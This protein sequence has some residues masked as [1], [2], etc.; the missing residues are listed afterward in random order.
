MH[1]PSQDRVSF[2]DESADVLAALAD[3]L[4]PPGAGFPAP[5]AVR[6]VEDF[7]TRY[8]AADDAAIIYLPAVT[9]SDVKALV[10]RVGAAFAGQSG[11]E[12][13]TAV[14]ALENDDAELFAKLRG[15]VYAGYY[16]RPEVR[17]AIATSL[18]AGRDF[19]GAPQ[20]YGYVDV[21]EEWD[22]SLLNRNG[23][24]LK[25]DEVEPVDPEKLEAL[26]ASLQPSSGQN[27]GGA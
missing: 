12:R 26:V 20:P 18:E 19:R 16:S 5:S 3:T 15:L 17:S 6:I 1:G 24:Y 25:T 10:Q 22:V 27:G 23:S 7:M 2:D 8:V 11:D 14:R 4:I 21:I 13:T 9:L